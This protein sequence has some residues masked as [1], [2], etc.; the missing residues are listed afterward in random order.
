MIELMD[1]INRIKKQFLYHKAIVG[2]IP[3]N[4]INQNGNFHY[5][6]G[7]YYETKAIVNILSKGLSREEHNEASH[8]VNH[9]FIVY[10]SE[11]IMDKMNGKFGF[12]KIKINDTNIEDF[13]NC[14]LLYILRDK[15]AHGVYRENKIGKDRKKPYTAEEVSQEIRKRFYFNEKLDGNDIY[16][17]PVDEVVIP[18]INA[19]I[20][21][22]K[23]MN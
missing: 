12:Q 21:E 19:C 8:S 22:I 15:L 11:L 9:W 13:S 10:C 4:M 3:P 16:T 7:G 6:S 1:E 14:Q 20:D 17:L 5:Q 2:Y 23:N 18:L